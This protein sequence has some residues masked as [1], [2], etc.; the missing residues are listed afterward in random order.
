MK[1]KVCLLLALTMI[2][3]AIPFSAFAEENYDK[4]LKEAIVKSRELFSIGKE[5]D[6][7]NHR[8]NSQEGRRIFY[9][10]WS[11]SKGKLGSIDVTMTVDGTVLGYGK[12]KQ[13]VDEKPKLPKV[14]KEEG[15]KI[16]E[17]FIKKVSPQVAANIKYIDRQQPLN[18]NS[19]NYNYYFVR[20]EK[21]I[22]YYGDNIDIYI[23]NSTGEIRNYYVNWDE[24]LIFQDSKD[25]ISP[26]KAQ[27][28]YREKIGLDLL[29]KSKYAE[30]KST[31][32]LSYA[33]LNVNLGIDAKDGNVIAL[34]DYAVY[35]SEDMGSA[36]KAVE[37]E[38]NLAEEKAV[39]DISD[40]ISQKDAEKV[41]REILSLDSEYKLEYINLYNNWRN[42]S[43]Y[44]WQMEFKKGTSPKEQYVNLRIDA[45]TKD[46]I[47]FYKY[48]PEDVNSKVKYDEKQALNIA[49]EYIK[50]V[51]P[52][53]FE[54]IELLKNFEKQQFPAEQ[55][56]YYFNFIRK[57]DNAYVEG[58]EILISVDVTNGEIMEYRIDWSKEEFPPKDNLISKDKAYNKL[59]DDIGMEL[60]YINPYIYDETSKAQ[61]KAILVYGLNS[62][63]PANIDANTGT[64]LNQRG[65]PFKSPTVVSY[66]DIDKSYAKEKINIL[67]QYGIT[68]SGE[69]F[70]PKEKINQKD[71]LCLLAK[72]NDP[73]YRVDDIEGNLYNYLIN[74]G[75]IKENEKSPEKIVTK[76]EGIKYIIRALKYDKVADISEIYK[77]LFNDTKDIDPTL[78]GYVSIAYGLKIV[79]GDKGYLNPKEELKREDAANM[80]YNYL[81]SGN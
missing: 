52:D 17:E 36:D 55:R 16:A 59:F 4:Q 24:D 5:Y 51:N 8:I 39:E 32:Y 13:N 31:R 53:K 66:K 68:L 11:D 70:K 75:I 64:I 21:G 81:F 33:P 76:E 50:K 61:K 77:D 48:G 28:L 63:K 69:E 2:L 42:D 12:W 62:D 57:I 46:I 65:E 29:Y 43:D 49:K 23:S 6:K 18:V 41:G 71:F 67:V 60:K 3:T 74:I 30:E 37:S 9:L 22:P 1:K 54:S 73:Y 19:D 80:I 47:S 15:L 10:N 72:A 25:V 34:Y 56:I 38:L 26:E 20:T 58:D 40:L 79:E 27:K 45:K 14:S 78:K 44:N 35:N 7:F